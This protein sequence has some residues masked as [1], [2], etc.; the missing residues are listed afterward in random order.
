MRITVTK[1]IRMS[2]IKIDNQTIAFQQYVE[3]VLEELDLL[4][5]IT[6]DDREKLGLREAKGVVEYQYEFFKEQ[7]LKDVNKQFGETR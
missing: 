5:S 2:V 4:I 7:M 3:D 6:T 1:G